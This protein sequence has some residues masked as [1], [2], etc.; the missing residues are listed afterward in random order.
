MVF[1]DWFFYLSVACGL[2]MAFSLG[3]NDVANAF[4]PVTAM[5][6]IAKYH[7]LPEQAPV[8]TIMMVLGGM[9]IA[10]GISTIG[11]RVIK[12]VG[13]KITKLNNTRGFSV[14]FSVA[15]TVLLA[16]R[17]GLPV[18]ST[19]VAVGA[20][21]GI[22]LAQGKKSVDYIMLAKI[23]CMWI[24]TIPIAAVTCAVVY[25]ILTWILL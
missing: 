1:F 25:T 9:G 12:T 22:G 18:S 10:V 14:D 2:F 23:V 3:A 6:L 13:E 21:T 15:S 20:V 16:S 19:T 7:H 4:G 17:L 11:H 5:Y 24:V 8:P